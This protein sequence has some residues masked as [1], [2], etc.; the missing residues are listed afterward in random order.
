MD[1]PFRKRYRLT[2]VVVVGAV[3][4]VI[5]AL[6]LLSPRSDGLAS[7]RPDATV[8]IDAS[9]ELG[10]AIPA[11]F[12]GLSLEYSALEAYAGD[13][14]LR[15]N[16][17]LQQL[18]RNLAPGQAPVLRIGGD[19][20]DWTWWAVAGV[21]RPPGVTFTLTQRWLQVAH[22]LSTPLGARLILGLNLAA[23]SPSLA[24]AEANALI[25]GLGASSVRA[26]ELGNE[27]EL[28]GSFAWYHTASGRGVT[29][30]ASGYDY[31]AF[32]NDFASFAGALPHVALAAPAFGDFAW[33]NHLGQFLAA[34]PQ[35]GIATLHRYPLQRCFVRRRS[36]HYP[37]ITN[38][39]SA[40]AS[41][42]LADS[43][44]P[45]AAIAH[46]HRV[47]LR[48]DELNTVSCGAVPRVSQTFASALWVIDALFEMARVG[49]DGVNMHTFPGAAYELFSFNNVNGRWQGSVS[50]EYYGLLMFAQAA[51]LGSRLLPVSEPR[52]SSLKIWATRTPDGR[53]RVVLINKDRARS[54]IAAV[55]VPGGVGTATL[56]RLEAPSA[57]AST[58][59]TLGGRSL[60]SQTD[61]GTLPGASHTDSITPI[62]ARYV[63]SLPPAS[64]ALLTLP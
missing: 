3:A 58:G 31:T 44:A 50:P 40:A 52:R 43:F 63:V 60:G 39:L 21:V 54:R 6:A 11:G 19:S 18:I 29:A 38:L 35:V 61:T 55:R 24:A 9:A 8:L 13:D 22:A 34:Q 2:D 32:A 26:L 23:G 10:R 25:G 37:T 41:T 14:P 45:Y 30:R 46:T 49:I 59:V 42:G 51:P 17:A 27:P 1:G 56:E 5:V 33:V 53:I 57:S 28:Y 47:P 15:V 62:N 7:A 48:I 4:V 36:P 64:A 12:L 20:A 16:P